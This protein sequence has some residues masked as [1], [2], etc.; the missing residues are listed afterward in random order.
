MLASHKGEIPFVDGKVGMN[1]RKA[2]TNHSRFT[3]DIM[4]AYITK[5][6]KSCYE[7]NSRNFTYEF[8]ELFN[9]S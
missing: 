9:M 6:M 3:H 2:L 4:V 1:F 7:E 8:Q 5:T